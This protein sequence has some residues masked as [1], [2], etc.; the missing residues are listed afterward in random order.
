[1][2]KIL[3]RGALTLGTVGVIVG[4]AAAFSAFEAHIINVTATIENALRVDTQPLSFGTVFP[5]E[6]LIL[7]QPIVIGLSGSFLQQNRVSHVA[8]VIKQ[9]PK[10]RVWGGPIVLGNTD[11]PNGTTPAN[12]DGSPYVQT[13]I[14]SLDLAGIAPVD[15][16][17]TGNPNHQVSA[18]DSFF[19][20]FVE[21]SPP[22][23]GPLR[24]PAWNLC[25]N[26]APAKNIGAPNDP[27]WVPDW[28]NL[29][30]DWY[31]FCYPLL[32]P[33][34]SKEAGTDTEASEASLAAFH[35][36]YD[37][38]TWRRGSL[39]KDDVVDTWELDIDVPCFVGY[40]DQAWSHLGW[41]LP[42]S[43]EHETFGTDLWIEVT[44]V[45]NAPTN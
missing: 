6:H 20:I 38:S 39:A 36:P 37:P 30:N 23:A 40:C 9:K 1:M 33:Y 2:K 32:G 13:E 44:D 4:G 26:Y 29:N 17:K 42:K 41:E 3:L 10:V 31:K 16:V 24:V 19:D 35:N 18:V 45:N 11:Q 7:G 27:H 25:E 14:L 22:P 15:L 43:L 5:Q 12:P 21:L 8:Y 28:G 34:L